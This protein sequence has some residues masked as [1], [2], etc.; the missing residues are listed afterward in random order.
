MLKALLHINSTDPANLN[1][2]ATAAI[3][4]DVEELF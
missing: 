3:P 2:N 4:L 1:S